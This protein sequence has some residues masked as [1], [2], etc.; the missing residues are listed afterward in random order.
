M[1][2][3]TEIAIEV[4]KIKATGQWPQWPLLPVVHRAERGWF[5][6][7]RTGVIH[8]DDVNHG[9]TIKVYECNI[10]DISGKRLGELP[11]AGEYL[12]V[13]GLLDAGWRGD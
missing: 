8:A 5:N 13:E 11:V 10:F 1:N 7:P 4:A 12:D 2:A 6:L 3:A 9:Q